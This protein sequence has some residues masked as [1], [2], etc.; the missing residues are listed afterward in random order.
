MSVFSATT[1]YNIQPPAAAGGPTYQWRTDAYSA[2]LV[3]AMPFS[4][5]TSLGMTSYKQDVSALIKGS[6]SNVSLV[7]SGSVYASGSTCSYSTASW[8]AEGYT[9][10]GGIT[11]TGG[12]MFGAPT[13]TTVNFASSNFVIEAYILIPNKSLNFNS[14]VFGQNSGDYLLADVSPPNNTI[15]FYI[16]GSGGGSANTWSNN[17]WYHVAWVRSGNNYYSYVNGVRKNNFSRAGSVPNSPDGFW[18]LLG[19]NGSANDSVPK[20]TQDFRLY[21]GTDKGYNTATIVPPPSIVQKIS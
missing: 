13:T 16:A 14:T 20:I 6:G 2:S 18:R 10:T 5:F 17:T 21:I 7:S 11:Q 3:L 19:Y 15:R 4:E 1:F 9:T 12:S 8:S